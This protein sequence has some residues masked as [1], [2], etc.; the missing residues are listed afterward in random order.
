LCQF[1]GMNILRVLD[2]FL[3]QRPF[4]AN[5]L[6]SGT[7]T[8]TSDVICQTLVEKKDRNTFDYIRTLR[9]SCLGFFFFGPQ[10]NLWFTKGLPKVSGYLAPKIFPA[11]IKDEVP[12]LATRFGKLLLFVTINQSYFS[13][14]MN[15]LFLF[16][17]GFFTHMA[18]EPAFK[19]V[20]EKWLKMV[21]ANN[22]VWPFIHVFNFWFTPQRH[23]ILVISTFSL[24]WNV[25]ISWLANSKPHQT[26]LPAVSP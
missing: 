1:S 13:L 3:K 7:L 24:F 20:Q 4:L 14:I 11:S 26:L 22:A 5:S 12:S 17:N 2:S 21:T 25:Y 16:L 6:I 8:F 9:M 10:A 15:P 18:V 23:H 19:E